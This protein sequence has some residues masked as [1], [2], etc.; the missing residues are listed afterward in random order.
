MRPKA[1]FNS[2]A[3]RPGSSVKTFRST[4]PG[5]Y[6]HGLGFVTKNF[7]KRKGALTRRPHS[8]GYVTLY[9]AGKRRRKDFGRVYF[10]GDMAGCLG[11]TPSPRPH[12]QESSAETSRAKPA[13]RG[14][15]RLPAGRRRR[16]S[17]PGRALRIQLRSSCPW[18]EAG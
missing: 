7:G 17:T 6:G 10:Q 11:M 9:A 8:N 5:K 3:W 1:S 4:L 15:P 2:L 13:R 12:A 18:L 14:I 16:R